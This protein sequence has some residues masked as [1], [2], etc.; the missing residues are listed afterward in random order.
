MIPAE[1]GKDENKGKAAETINSG[2][3][4]IDYS[5]HYGYNNLNL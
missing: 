5:N 4:F 2:A 3:F 1:A